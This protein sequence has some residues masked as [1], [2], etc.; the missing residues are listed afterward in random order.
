MRGFFSEKSLPWFFLM[1]TVTTSACSG[2]SVKI[3]GGDSGLLLMAEVCDGIDNDDDGEV[4]EDLLV[5]YV[6]DTDGDGCAAT[7]GSADWFCPSDAPQDY[8]P[9]DEFPNCNDCNDDEPLAWTGAEEVCDSVDNDCDGGIDNDAI[10]ERAW[11]YDGDDDGFGNSDIILFACDQPSDHSDIDGDCD[12]VEPNAFPGNP[13]V[14]G[15]GIDNDCDGYSLMNTDADAD[16]FGSCDL[17][18]DCDDADSNT[19][20]GA[21]ELCDG[22]DNDCDLSLPADEVDVDGDTF[23]VCAGDCDDSRSDVNPGMIELCDGIDND[24]D[25]NVPADED[26]IDIDG[27]R[28][29]DGDCDDS[30]LDIYPG[31]PEL[32]DGVDN[33]CDLQVPLDELDLDLDGYS[34]CQGDC[35]GLS[36]DINPGMVELCSTVGVDDDCNGLVDD[37]DPNVSDA[38]TW[39]LDGDGDGYGDLNS[40]LDACRPPMDYLVDSTDCDDSSPDVFPGNPEICDGLDNDCDLLVPSNEQDVD[41]DGISSCEGDCDDNDVNV[42]PGAPEVVADGVDQDC[43]GVDSCYEDLDGDGFGGVAATVVDGLDLSCMNTGASGTS[44]DCDD[45]DLDI[46]PGAPELCDGIDNDC[47]AG[48][49]DGLVFLDYYVDLDVDGFG[50]LNDIT[51]TN[52]CVPVPGEV[53]DNSDCDD[54]LPNIYPGANETVADGIDQDCNLVDSCYEDLDLDGFGGEIATVIQGSD[55]TCSNPGESVSADDCDD[56]DVGVWAGETRYLDLDGDGY[57]DPTTG[58]FDCPNNFAANYLIDGTDCRDDVF[59]VNPGASPNE[60]TVWDRDCDGTDD[61]AGK[62]Y[63]TSLGDVFTFDA[64]SV[65]LFSDEEGD[66]TFAGGFTNW[67]VYT[68]LF[69]FTDLDIV[70]ADEFYNT[71]LWGTYSSMELLSPASNSGTDNE[72]LVSS[73][74][75]VTVGLQYAL[76]CIVETRNPPFNEPLRMYTQTDYEAGVGVDFMADEAILGGDFPHVC[77]A[78]TASSTT[79]NFLVCTGDWLDDP[80]AITQCYLGEGTY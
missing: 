36:N 45:S 33:D 60:F 59:E 65:N 50:D 51:P 48:P 44:D 66:S 78:F 23:L 64:A 6:K 74:V 7:D 67:A 70:V 1:L 69:G 11:F 37:M 72:C 12:D 8:Y 75:N 56:G 20:P 18:P 71:T 52:A 80:G 61:K 79:E 46:Y 54:S 13:E 34:G 43:D 3:P 29:C 55:L 38:A 2:G 63:I 9:Q 21:P 4:D 76:C 41:V 19:Y 27:F 35:D 68:S 5:F 15:D 30:D 42:Y 14:C 58:L 47:L 77:G 17:V 73:S 39:Y 10:D 25:S 22:V 28:V 31:A 49:D 26:D 62:T 32:C 53:T 16:G 57:G 40:P 24:C